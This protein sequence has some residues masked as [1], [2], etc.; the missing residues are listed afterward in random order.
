MPA[1]ALKA[2]INE[3]SAPTQADVAAMQRSV[4]LLSQPP[5]P[6][7]PALPNALATRKLSAAVKAAQEGLRANT[8]RLQTTL[9]AEMREIT[10]LR[11]AVA[12][13]RPAVARLRA[14]IDA[15]RAETVEA[16]AET[17]TLR[18]QLAVLKSRAAALPGPLAVRASAAPTPTARPRVY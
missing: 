15:L 4:R 17:A 3:S 13:A 14:D 12:A 9:D 7:A 16:E 10:A 6:G 8:A 18:E 1:A 5:V 11:P 2:Q